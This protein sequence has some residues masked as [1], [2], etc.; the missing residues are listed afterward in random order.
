MEK[1]IWES[2]SPPNYLPCL[3]LTRPLYGGEVESPPHGNVMEEVISRILL[4]II[5]R[6]PSA[7]V[8]ENK[9]ALFLIDRY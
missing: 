8:S 3:R 6:H 7:I 1:Q 5:T 9:G 4:G 2:S